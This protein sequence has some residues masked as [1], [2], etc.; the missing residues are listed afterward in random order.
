M[1][2]TWCLRR[3]SG[4]TPLPLASGTDFA[5]LLSHTKWWLL[6]ASLCQ[7]SLQ[8]PREWLCLQDIP[9]AA[10]PAAAHRERKAGSVLNAL[11]GKQPPAHTQPQ[12]KNE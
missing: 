9:L 2:P 11:T 4:I 1:P 5:V 8:S 6:Q 12:K 10:V 7:P 3:P